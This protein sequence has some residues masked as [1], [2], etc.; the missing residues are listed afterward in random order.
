LRFL[1]VLAVGRC[2]I[3]SHAKKLVWQYLD[4]LQESPWDAITV[5]EKCKRRDLTANLETLRSEKASCFRLNA[6][7]RHFAVAVSQTCISQQLESLAASA[8]QA[9]TDMQDCEERLPEVG[10]ALLQLFGD[11]SSRAVL[12]SATEMLQHL[13]FLGTCL[14]QEKEAIDRMARRRC[15]KNYAW[16]R[17]ERWG[18]WTTVPTDDMILARTN[19][20]DVIRSLR[21]LA[22][23]CSVSTDS[24]WVLVGDDTSGSSKRNAGNATISSK[25]LGEHHHLLHGGPDGE[26]KRCE[27]TGRWVPCGMAADL[28][29]R[30]RGTRGATAGFFVTY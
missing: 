18:T 1:R 4:D 8:Q 23:D 9:A 19:D 27:L 3:Q 5:L 20:P 29:E 26:Y 24:D 6:A 14:A 15:P 25:A 22:Q 28:A 21:A 13:A 2:A 11:E 30:D 10:N 16:Q 17:G 7:H 12:E